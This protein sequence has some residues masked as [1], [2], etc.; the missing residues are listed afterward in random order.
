MLQTFPI[1]GI[2]LTML[3][4]AP[5][6]AQPAKPTPIVIQSGP[7]QLQS[8]VVAPGKAEFPPPSSMQLPAATEPAPSGHWI[9]VE[10]AAAPTALR[11]HLRLPDGQGLMVAAVVQDSPAAKAGLAPYDVLL[12]AGGTPLAEP[13]DL[14]AA[15]E[16]AKEAKLALNV[17]RGGKPLSVA[18]TPVKRPAQPPV[19]F[20]AAPDPMDLQKV[21]K[22]LES[23]AHGQ[24]AAMQAPLHIDI[25]RPGAQI[26]PPSALPVQPLPSNLSIAI[27]REGDQP[28]KIVVKRG[29]DRWELT[30]KDIDK[31]P[32]DVRP[33]V[34][35]MLGHGVFG[36]QGTVRQPGSAIDPLLEKRF[37]DMNRRMD[38]MLKMMEEMSGDYFQPPMPPEEEGK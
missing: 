27:T 5:A 23:M 33:A 20:G 14:V 7:I 8:G 30:E 2:V 25:L 17:I 10:V 32:A 3:G 38:R 29:N 9:G 16:K 18:V 4:A 24:A 19:A 21:R 1:L 36:M 12:S 37:D 28:A 35:R 13:Q 34:E 11:S 15:V 22:W 6:L 31:L 26:V